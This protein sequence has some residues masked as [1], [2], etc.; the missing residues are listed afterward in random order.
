MNDQATIEPCWGKEAKHGPLKVEKKGAKIYALSLK[1]ILVSI[2][3][4]KFENFILF[5][6]NICKIVIP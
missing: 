2:L 6:I 3:V 5:H 1:L 4:F